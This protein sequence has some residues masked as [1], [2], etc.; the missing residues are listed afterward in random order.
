M[1]ATASGAAR[2]VLVDARLDKSVVGQQETHEPQQVVKLFDDF[3]GAGEHC[4]RNFEAEC[5]C[6]LEVDDEF[7]LCGL[8]HWKIGRL[9]T[10]ENSPSVNTHLAIPVYKV[11]SV[12]NES[13]GFGELA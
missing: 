9:L 6:C 1:P 8:D 11:V 13:A 7:K 3:V 10:L 5:P 2:P 12:T 4:R